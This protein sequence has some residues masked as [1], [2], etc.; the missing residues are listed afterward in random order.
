MVKN[1]VE[2]KSCNKF[3]TPRLWH[4]NMYSIIFNRS[5]QHICPICGETMYRTGGGLTFLG[6]IVFHL[7]AALIIWVAAGAVAQDLF[8]LSNSASSNFSWFI[9]L[10]VSAIYIAKRFFGFA[11]TSFFSR[12]NPWQ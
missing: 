12:K 11:V 4:D 5:N 1:G 3:V 10:I 9:L 7:I 2:C 6:S 8:N